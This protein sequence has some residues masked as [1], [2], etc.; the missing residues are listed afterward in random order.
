M[1]APRNINKKDSRTRE[2]SLAKLAKSPGI[3]SPIAS[4]S[5]RYGSV[6]FSDKGNA[7]FLRDK[8]RDSELCTR[9]DASVCSNSSHRSSAGDI[10][11]GTDAD[12]EAPTLGGIDTDFSTGLDD[13]NLIQEVNK[14]L[15]SN[16]NVSLQLEGGD[17][18]RDLYRFSH[19]TTKHPIKRSKS[20]SSLLN[21][22]ERRGSTAG[23]LNVPGGFRRDFILKH[24]CNDLTTTKASF[25]TRN[26][27]EFLSIYGHFA[28]ENLENEDDL[29]AC[30]YKPNAQLRGLEDEETLLLSSDKNIGR[31]PT[32]T[33][34]NKKAYFLLL[35]AFVGTGVLFLPKA[36]SNGGL[37]FSILTLTFFGVISYWCY[38]ILVYAKLS[39]N[40]ASFAEIGHKL[41]GRWLQSLILFSIILS[42]IGFVA[43]YIVFTAE[44]LRAFLANILSLELQDLNVVWFI[45]AQMV[46]FLPLSLVRD[47]TKLSLLAL[48]ANVLILGGLLTI[49]YYT[50]FEL[51]IT[52]NGKIGS[53]VDFFF[54]TNEFSLFIGVAIFAFEGI[55]LIIPIQESMIYPKSFPKV[56]FLVIL[57]ISLVFIGI[58]TLGYLTFGCDTQT[59]IIL[60]LPQESPMVITTQLLYAIAILFSTPL[61][62]FPAVR[63]I[64]QKLFTKTGKRSYKVKWEKNFMRFLFVIL[65]TSV[66]IYG[67]QNLDLFVSLVGCFACIPLVY[68]YPPLLHLRACFP[69]HKPSLKLLTK[70]QSIQVIVDYLLLFFGSIAMV[71]STYSILSL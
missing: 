10:F 45:L 48:L 14:H 52:R 51:F 27:L 6:G 12:T 19:H 31:S 66:A 1:S 65:T 20:T 25:L 49:L 54:N 53:S 57:T 7:S 56:L 24:S 50:A 32:G 13:P 9:F 15:R 71:Y 44:N 42:Q 30:H 63:L 70:G 22:S 58:G 21:N 40:V 34:S 60:N 35:K 61:Q 47:I 37:L 64:E 43:T 26:F 4:C 5:P 2:M 18:T 69:N 23:S 38:L 55:G 59:V 68:M 36:F 39:T 67:G 28:G 3:E 46:I 41:Y 8:K 29:I 16:S 17:I 62:L 33:A 11:D